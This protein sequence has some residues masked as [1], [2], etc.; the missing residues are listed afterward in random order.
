MPQRQEEAWGGGGRP[1]VA[2]RE[3]LAAVLTQ[4][5]ICDIGRGWSELTDE[6]N[7]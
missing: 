4:G 6:P 1:D 5:S 3:S 7:T 2:E